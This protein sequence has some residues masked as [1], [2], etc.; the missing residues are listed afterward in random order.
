[1]EISVLFSCYF[2]TFSCVYNYWHSGALNFTVTANMHN[3][4]QCQW[5]IKY[6]CWHAHCTVWHTRQVHMWLW[7]E[8]RRIC[9]HDQGRYRSDMEVLIKKLDHEVQ[10]LVKEKA[11]HITTITNL[12]NQYK[13][14][15]KWRDDSAALGVWMGSCGC[16]LAPHRAWTWQP[17]ARMGWLYCMGHPFRV[18]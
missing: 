15:V 12:E 17:R 2:S 8:Q 3:P 10:A 18:I 5:R 9:Q 7:C 16:G 1:M 4:K 13:W 11:G 6:H 14:I